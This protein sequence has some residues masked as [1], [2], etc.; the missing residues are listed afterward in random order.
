M[1]LTSPLKIEVK[2]AIQITLEQNIKLT[3]SVITNL[4]ICSESVFNNYYLGKALI[5]SVYFKSLSNLM[6]SFEGLVGQKIY[7]NNFSIQRDSSSPSSMFFRGVIN[8]QN[9]YTLR[10]IIISV[11]FIDE[12]DR[13]V[14]DEKL[15][16]EALT[17][18][19]SYQF[20]GNVEMERIHYAKKKNIHVLETFS[21]N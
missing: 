21:I 19:T 12:S 1:F 16:I 2:T 15:Y 14:H 11:V 8:N 6:E 20:S 5:N 9:D 10:Y 18:N 17:A 3:A 13:V 7:M 4:N